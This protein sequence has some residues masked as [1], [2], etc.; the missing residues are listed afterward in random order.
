MV[1]L[2]F[3]F[4]ASLSITYASGELFPNVEANEDMLSEEA[5][6][7]IQ[8]DSGELEDDGYKDPVF[9][10]IS[11]TFKGT[12]INAGVRYEEQDEWI[13]D[14]T[15]YQ[16]VRIKVTEGDYSNIVFVKYQLSYFHL[17]S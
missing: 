4:F 12:V 2:F 6:S 17:D 8:N 7:I 15:P 5:L 13:Q 11:K 3:I 10:G 1:M 9:K 14:T 16:D